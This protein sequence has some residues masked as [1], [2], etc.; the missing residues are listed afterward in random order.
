MDFFVV[1]VEVGTGCVGDSGHVA[2]D[3]GYTACRGN[4]GGWCVEPC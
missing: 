3:E 1:A 4:G 2:E